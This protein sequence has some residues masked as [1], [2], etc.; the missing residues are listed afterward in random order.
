MKNQLNILFF[1]SSLVSAY[2]NG[3]ATYYRGLLNALA[4]RGHR[5]TF[6]EPDVYDRQLHRDIADPDWARVVVYQPT[7]PALHAALELGRQADVVIKASGVGVFDAELEAMVLELAT[8]SRRVGFCDVDA[9]AT[10]A[11]VQDDPTDPFRALVP[12]YDFVFTYGGGPPVLAGYAALGA[13][14]CQAIYNAVD[15]ATHYPAP[16]EP[17]F[18]AAVSFMG[19]RL[20]DREARVD[21]FFL[22]AARLSGQPFLLAGNGWDD[23]PLPENVRYLGHLYTR[24]HNAFNSSSRLVLNVS[25]NSMA[26]V[27]F[28]PATRVFEAAAAGACIVTDAWEGVE[29]FFKPGI[30]ILVAHGA[31]DVARFATEVDAARAQS[32]GQRA[33]RRALL[34]HS[35]AARAEELEQLLLEAGE[36]SSAARVSTTSAQLEGH[37]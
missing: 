6:C 29:R 33:L 12:E 30:E 10:L 5:I 13:R 31:E 24:D 32:I 3:A 26:D 17:R 4:R 20:P 9:P 28:S 35:Y 15:P 25:R 1:G 37:P 21:Q 7:L 34:D 11:R 27:G 16:P 23:K 18:S 22:E 8:S 2:W 36:G 19:N 14:R